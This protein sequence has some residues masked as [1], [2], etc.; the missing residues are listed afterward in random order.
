MEHPDKEGSIPFLDTKCTP[1]PQ[2]IYT[3]IQCIENP[4]TMTDTWIG[5]LTIQY[6]QNSSVVQALMHRT[7]IVCST[8]QLLAKETDYLIKVLC[9]N[10][11]PDWL[12]EK[13]LQQPTCRPNS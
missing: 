13:K 5:T 2:P 3:N 9:L 8:P 1:S 11:Y 12:F 4:L 10:S 6:Q 7:K